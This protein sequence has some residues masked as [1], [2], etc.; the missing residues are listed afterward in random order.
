[1]VFQ[2]KVSPYDTT[3]FAFFGSILEEVEPMAILV[4]DPDSCLEEP[5]DR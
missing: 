2:V 1:M 3:S 4:P 5:I